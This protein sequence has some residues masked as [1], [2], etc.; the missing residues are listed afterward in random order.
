M[1]KLQKSTRQQSQTTR[2]SYVKSNT[3]VP[4]TYSKKQFKPII[5]QKINIPHHEDHDR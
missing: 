2:K 5:S 3:S 4:I 1:P